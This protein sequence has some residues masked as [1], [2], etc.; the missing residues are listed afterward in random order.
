M[1]VDVQ[2]QNLTISSPNG[3]ILEKVNFTLSGG[4][5]HALIGPN[6]A[7]KTTLLQ[8]MLGFIPHDGKILFAGKTNPRI[9]YVPQNADIDRSAPMTVKDFLSAGITSRPIWSGISGLTSRSVKSVVGDVNIESLLAHRLGDLSGG[10]FQRVLLANA[11]LQKPD[12]LLLD[13][14]NTGIDIT[15]SEHFCGL[16][17]DVHKTHELTTLIVTHDLGVVADHADR[18]I[19][20]NKTVLFD[21]ESPD[22]LTRENLFNLFGPHSAFIT[23]HVHDDSSHSHPHE[24]EANLG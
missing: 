4:R 11:L 3:K 14:P 10:E 17:E 19:G 16:I 24:H 8:A 12:L 15:G 20:L 22:I 23:D 21:G 1:S 6:G 7:G 5:F 13:E 2:I 18:V 9:G